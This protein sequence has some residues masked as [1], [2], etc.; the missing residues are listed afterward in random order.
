M[1]PNKSKRIAIT[2]GASGI[3]KSIAD[4]LCAEGHKV[5]LCD[6]DRQGFGQFT[7]AKCIQADVAVEADV[8]HFMEQAISVMGG[9]DVLVNNAGVAG[10]TEGVEN[11]SFED[12][13]QTLG[14]NLDGTFLATKYAVPELRAA[15]GGSI[16]NI[17][18]S[19]ALFG[20]PMRSPY[21]ATKWAIIGLTK[22]WAMELGKDNIR[23]NAICPGCVAGPRIEGVIEREA[24]KRGCAYGAYSTCL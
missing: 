18:S 15:T 23:V 13:K 21:S 6:I 5:V 17:A 9:L 16:I 3:G 22:T 8:K 24:Q 2:A 20:T 1:N 4:R 11:V 12:W 19:S 7:Q 10:P 14:V